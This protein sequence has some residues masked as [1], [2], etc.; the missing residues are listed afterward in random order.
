MTEKKKMKRF[1]IMVVVFYSYPRR[2][3]RLSGR[4]S[5]DVLVFPFSSSCAI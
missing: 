5:I 3:P 1:K 2:Y 4:V